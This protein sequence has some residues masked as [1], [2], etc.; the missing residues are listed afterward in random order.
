MSSEKKITIRA[1]LRSLR[2][3]QRQIEINDMKGPGTNNEREAQN[4]F[5]RFM[6]NDTSLGD[7]PRL[8]KL[9]VVEDEAL[10]EVVE[11]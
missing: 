5:R 10:L 1:I 3:G 8:K 11:Q 7:K 4:K 6:E 9:P 2:K